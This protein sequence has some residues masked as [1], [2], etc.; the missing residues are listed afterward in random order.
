MSDQVQIISIPL[1]LYR[2]LFERSGGSHWIGGKLTEGMCNKYRMP[3][4]DA[5][6]A[7]MGS[8]EDMEIPEEPTLT[9]GLSRGLMWA[10][11]AI[12]V[13]LALKFLF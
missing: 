5:I 6:T 10:V 4:P 9:A 7:D 3:V 12:G 2:W 11:I 1:P 8:W 13:A